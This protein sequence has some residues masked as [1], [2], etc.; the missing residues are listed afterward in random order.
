MTR[1]RM[2][3]LVVA[4][5]ATGC[6]SSRDE[7]TRAQPLTSA[8]VR[9][10]HGTRSQL[11]AYCANSQL[12]RAIDASNAKATI[13][14]SNRLADEYGAVDRSVARYVAVLRAKPDATPPSGEP[15]TT[16]TPRQDAQELLTEELG[17]CT[18]AAARDGVRA[19]RS[20]LRTALAGLPPAPQR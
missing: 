13:S 5:G 2:L 14:L 6:G 19:W 1:A 17:S 3:I 16:Q 12:F 9:V 20:R 15:S 7:P 8:E 18:A 11:G 10:L 4:V